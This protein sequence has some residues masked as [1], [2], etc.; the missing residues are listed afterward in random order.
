LNLRRLLMKHANDEKTNS[1]ETVKLTPS[2]IVNAVIA[3]AGVGEEEVEIIGEVGVEMTEETFVVEAEDLSEGPNVIQDHHLHVVTTLETE[4]HF[5]HESQIPTFLAGEVDVDEMTE[6]GPLPIQY[7]RSLH[8]QIQSHGPHPADECVPH[9]GLDHLLL[10]GIS[11]DRLTDENRT[12]AEGA[13]GE[14]GVQT[15]EGGDQQPQ[16]LPYPA[17]LVQP[18]EEDQSPTPLAHPHHLSLVELIDETS[19]RDLDLP[20]RQDLRVLAHGDHLALRTEH[21]HQLQRLKP[22]RRRAL[23]LVEVMIVG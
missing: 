11:L 6:G 10:A 20:Q 14:E 9:P 15:M 3:A 1:A 23:G 17:P 19:L 4:L 8:A 2:V 13:E 16:R 12:E 5:D 22:R 21:N 7:H 18:V